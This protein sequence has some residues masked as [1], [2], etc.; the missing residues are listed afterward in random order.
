MKNI[1]LTLLALLSVLSLRAQSRWSA[2]Q[3]NNW[4][5]QQQ[6]PRG[7]NYQP[8]SAVNQLEMFQAATFAPQTIDRELG[9]A[10]ELGFNAMRVFLHHIA[11]T[12]D[13]D[14]FKKRLNQYLDISAR[15]GIK[16][17]L[18]FFDDCWNDE[19]HAGK[20]PEPKTGIHNSGWVRDPGTAIRNNPDSLKM[21]ESYVKD[22]MIM[23]KDDK[24]V[25]LWDLY[26]EPGN[27]QYFNNSLPLLKSVFSWAKE[28]NP[29]QPISAGV[30]NWGDKFTELNKFQ[31]E[32]SDVIT[33]HNYGYIDA[34]MKKIA[35]LQKYGRPLICTEYMARKN[36]SL[37]QTIM[38]MLK[39]E[40]IGAINWGFISGKTNTIYAWGTPMPDGK[41]PEL[42]F[43]D[44]L[45]KDGTPFSEVEVNTIKALTGKK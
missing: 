16:T 34:H 29:S 41:E 38:P 26:N 36:G 33:Y 31:L 17:I 35:E 8:S 4:Y 13:K 23:L 3:A 1:I 20:Q 11:W 5:K 24:R 9:W 21:L 19:Y 42:W 12:S 45:R 6:W 39:K 28:V 37:F 27:N 10:Q 30:W 40:K 18:V 32:N 15:H 44:I 43:H 14:G 22:I 25:L 7:C 2:E